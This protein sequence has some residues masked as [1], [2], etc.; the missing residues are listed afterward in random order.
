LLIR[1]ATG[2]CDP[3]KHTLA[4]CEVDDFSIRC[5]DKTIRD[6][7]HEVAPSAESGVQEASL[8]DVR[9]T[10]SANANQPPR[11]RKYFG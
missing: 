3:Q 9:D 8:V 7:F 2:R 1:F 5:F 10:S 4:R 11:A 6:A